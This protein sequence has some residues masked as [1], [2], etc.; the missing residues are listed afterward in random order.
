MPRGSGKTTRLIV[1]SA[2]SN[3]PILTSTKQQ[4]DYIF[5]K[6]C[7]M[8]IVIPFPYS[9]SEWINDSRYKFETDG[10]LIDELDSV[11]KILLHTKVYSTTLTC[12]RLNTSDNKKGEY[13]KMY[14]TRTDY[15][16]NYFENY[17]KESVKPTLR[18]G[19]DKICSFDI[20]VPNKVMKVYFYDNKHEKIVCH[21]EDKFDL[22]SGLFI[23]LAKHMYKDEFTSDGIEFFA[24][25]L[26]YQKFYSKMVDRVIKEYYK[27][28]A[29]KKKEIETKKN[30]ELIKKRQAEKKRKY[31]ERRNQKRE[32]ERNKALKDEREEMVNII[33]EAI[34]RS[35]QSD[36][37]C[38]N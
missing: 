7:E 8:N 16:I 18:L 14:Y 13:K 21:P 31:K 38:D 28:E 33:A 37:N 5:R 32:L 17:F 20:I 15:S 24:K 29:D 12:D 25:L 9:V 4:A 35:K 26:S 27:K 22:K 3:Y 34:T 1:E 19:E 23:A 10:V 2:C 36:D 30:N 6:A 11:L